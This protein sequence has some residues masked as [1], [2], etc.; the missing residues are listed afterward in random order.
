MNISFLY[1]YYSKI[2][3]FSDRLIYFSFLGVYWTVCYIDVSQMSSPDAIC[4]VLEQHTQITWKAQL[5]DNDMA[6]FV[7]VETIKYMFEPN[8]NM[9]IDIWRGC[10][11]YDKYTLLTES[12]FR[13][14]MEFQCAISRTFWPALRLGQSLRTGPQS[15]EEIFSYL[16]FQHIYLYK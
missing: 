10:H 12:A 7:V 5:K 15:A 6:L 14:W 2:S 16:V 9:F 13:T 1:A 3:N 4:T 8:L 11:Q